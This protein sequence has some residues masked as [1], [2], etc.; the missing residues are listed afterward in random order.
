ME[1]ALYAQ[2]KQYAYDHR[3]TVTE[4]VRA[5]IVWRLAQ[6]G[7]QKPLY[8]EDAPLALRAPTLVEPV[9]AVQDTHAVVEPVQAM[10]TTP[11]DTGLSE[12]VS[13][14]AKHRKTARAPEGQERPSAQEPARG[15]ASVDTRPEDTP[16]VLQAAQ[17]PALAR[18]EGPT[19]D[20]TRYYLSMLCPK[21]HDYHGTG[22]SLRREHNKSC[23][24]CENEGK[25]ARRQAKRQAVSA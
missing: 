11:A 23:R 8:G 6:P 7:P 24:D 1:P 5:G 25:H 13:S 19:F 17:N 3:H 15:T 14:R 10:Q 9:Q 4:L 16:T 2:L 20:A 21:G 12:G 22:Q 18:V